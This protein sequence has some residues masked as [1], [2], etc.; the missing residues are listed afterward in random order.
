MHPHIVQG[1]INRSGNCAGDCVQ[2]LQPRRAKDDGSHRRNGP[3]RRTAVQTFV[4]RVYILLWLLVR[5][6]DCAGS[7]TIDAAPLP[8]FNHVSWL[9]G[10]G[11]ITGKW[12]IWSAAL[13]RLQ[14]WASQRCSVGCLHGCLLGYPHAGASTC[15]CPR[16]SAC[17][18]LDAPWPKQQY[19]ETVLACTGDHPLPGGWPVHQGAREDSQPPQR[20]P[21]DAL[22]H[23]GRGDCG[24]HL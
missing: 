8:L 24:S 15:N 21:A 19:N 11:V 22:P 5:L 14:S 17:R 10:F 9:N 18:M 12:A 6:Y 23:R 13:Q 2:L 3:C 4:H 1:A 16:A 20:H 7:S